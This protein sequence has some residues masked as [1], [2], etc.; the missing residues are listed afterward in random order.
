MV[1][2]CAVNFCIIFVSCD[3]HFI[4][5]LTMKQELYFQYNVI[6]ILHTLNRKQEN[7]YFQILQKTTYLSRIVSILIYTYCIYTSICMLL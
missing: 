1:I 5:T 6:R 7:V 4:Q 3:L 2:C